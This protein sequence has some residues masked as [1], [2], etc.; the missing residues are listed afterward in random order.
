MAITTTSR[1]TFGTRLYDQLASTEAGKNLFLS[2]FSIEVALAMCAVGAKGE[3]RRVL[4]DLIGAPENVDA[5][6]GQYARLL[7]SLYADEERPFQLAIAN[8]LW[9]QQGYPFKADF[10]EA[11]AAF[12]DGALHVVNFRDEPDKAVQTINSWVSS[13][14][15]DKI[16]ELVHRS[17]IDHDTRL[18]LTNAIYFKGQWQT[19]FEKTATRDKDWHGSNSSRKVPMMHQKGGYLYYENEEFQ[20]LDLPYKGRRLSML[21]LLPRKRDGLA[22]LEKLCIAGDAYRQ[23]TEGL[24]YEE[25]VLL[26][27]PRFKMETEFQ[28]SQVL[29]AMHAELAFSDDADFT[30]IGNERLKISEVVHKAFVEVNEEG[31]EAAAATAVVMARCG[32][33]GTPAPQP[34]VFRADH[35][36]LFFIRDQKTKSVLFSGRLLDPK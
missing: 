3:T 25:T 23:V 7:E 2:P 1:S 30:G 29:C 12:Y 31:T 19:E 35:P 27:L 21:I 32:G 6:N 16:K 4:A 17:L 18:I 20:A 28:L 13:K 14:T 8:S 15:R 24:D 33:L 36:F 5:Q 9:G 26:S 11:I 10:Q 34:K 22:A